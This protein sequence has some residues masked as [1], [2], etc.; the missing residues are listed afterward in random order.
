MVDLAAAGAVGLG[1]AVAGLV[2]P[3]VVDLVVPV[4]GLVAGVAGSSRTAFTERTGF[5]FCVGLR[6]TIN[7]G[8]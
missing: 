6:V 3:D 8:G 2:V 7:L 5:L 4:V 1:L